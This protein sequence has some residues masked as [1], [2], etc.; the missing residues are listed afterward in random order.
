M[1][2][3]I[4]MPK[5]YYSVNS[6]R[7]QDLDITSTPRSTLIATTSTSKIRNVGSNIRFQLEQLNGW[8]KFSEIAID[9]QNGT[10]KSSI[11]KNLNRK[12]LKINEIF[13]RVSCGSDYNHRPLKSIDYMFIQLMIKSENSIWDRC[14]YSNLIFY[15]VHHLMYKFSET[16]I[17][18]DESI[19]WPILN[20]MALDTCLLDT[21]A[22][23]QNKKSIPTIFLVCSNVDLIGESLRSR[24]INTNSIND[25]WNSKEYN[26]QMAQYHVY[27]WFG[28]ILQYPTFDIVDFFKE[29]LTVDDMHILIASKINT[30]AKNENDDNLKFIPNVEKYDAFEDIISMYNNDILIYEHSRK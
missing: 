19:I 16:S 5:C 18:N 20:N 27:R 17:P 4:S 2:Y 25:I 29:G 14:V 24:G 26:Y 8:N 28:K 11:S 12:Y 15:Y 23:T 1:N 6:R 3:N 13:P 7:K 22:Y 10:T 9:G 21:L 30:P